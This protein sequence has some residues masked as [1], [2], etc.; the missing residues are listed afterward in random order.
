MGLAVAAFD[1]PTMNEY[2]EDGKTGYLFSGKEKINLDNLE[3]IG[4]NAREKS[5]IGYKSWQKSIPR[6]IEFINS[7]FQLPAKYNL[8]WLAPKAI[9]FVRKN[10]FGQFDHLKQFL[11]Y[12]LQS[13]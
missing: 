12:K 1:N 2:I 6:M 11:K 7:E 8:L 4:E 5:V 10:V 13:K 9:Y 3:Q